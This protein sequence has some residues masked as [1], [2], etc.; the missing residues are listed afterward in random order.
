MTSFAV[1]RAHVDPARRPPR[2][3]KTPPAVDGRVE[4]VDGEPCAAVAAGE[5]GWR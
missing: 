4:P 5:R 1:K 3:P 2:S